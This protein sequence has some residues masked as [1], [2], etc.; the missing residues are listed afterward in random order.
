MSSARRTSTLGAVT[1]V[2]LLVSAVLGTSAQGASP[3]TFSTP[4][5]Y[6]FTVPVGIT[7]LYVIAIGA[8]GGGC[9]GAAG[10]EGAS[11]SASV[12]VSGG[13]QLFVGVGGPGGGGDFGVCPD[14]SGGA[15]GAGGGGAGG[16]G[17]NDGNADGGGG[18]GGAS[19]VGPGAPDFNSLFVVAGGGGGATYQ[20][21]GGDAGSP[22]SHFDEGQAGGAGAQAIG[23]AGGAADNANSAPGTN[24][25]ALTGGAG[26]H[27]DLT[28]SNSNGG[29]GGGGGYYGGGGGGG[30]ED[31]DYSGAGGG[32]SS[33]VTPAATFHIAPTLSASAPKI[34]LIYPPP[35]PPTATVSSPAANG[36]YAVGQSVATSFSCSEGT[37][38]L[39]L[40][41]CNDS[42]GSDT[43][44]G[45]SGHLD[46]SDIGAHTYKV[47]AAS[48][49]GLTSTTTIAYNVWVPPSATVSSPASG[50]TYTVGQ[51]VATSFSCT[52]GAGGLGL[53]SCADST[54]TSA[55]F[56]GNGHLDTS[57]AG[58]HTYTVTATSV[59]GLTNSAAVTY[60]V[61]APTTPGG[62]S[63]GSGGSG[64]GG[65]S[66][67]TSG[68]GGGSNK[69]SLVFALKSI[70]AVRQSIRLA[71]TIPSAGTLRV[72]VSSG[73]K[74][75]CKSI[76]TSVNAGTKTV[77]IKLCARATAAL[78]RLSKKKKLKFAVSATFT[79]A[80]KAKA[81]KTSVG[82]PGTRRN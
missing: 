53:A 32:G 3:Q 21:P 82:V 29:G 59:G 33:F 17:P 27:A 47:F 63:D 31:F 10:G 78:K 60:T 35:A 61:V 12:P 55:T 8:H 70:T 49:D 56:L 80:G 62:G 40:A 23:G 72:T 79:A 2:A 51:S 76:K 5:N 30:S 46:T 48:T 65:G 34:T 77:S 57:T 19:L 18:G 15:A 44:T 54:G 22:G 71:F 6:S 26:G 14:S 67:G 58:P 20:R 81:V 36:A 4:G 42:T 64:G 43:G 11:V 66:G 52:E 24:G 75:T 7:S 9:F 1:L 38:G 13:Q 41:S 25:T 73:K 16:A 69:A 50:A 39:G 45:G 37:G 28:A 68:G 74:I